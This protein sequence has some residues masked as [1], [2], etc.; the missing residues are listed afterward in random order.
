MKL[1]ELYKLGANMLLTINHDGTDFLDIKYGNEVYTLRSNLATIKK[2]F[3]EKGWDL[4]R[5]KIQN[6]LR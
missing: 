2:Y 3:I 5:L 4:N 1:N 6:R